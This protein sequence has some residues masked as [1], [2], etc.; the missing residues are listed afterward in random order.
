MSHSSSAE[1][2]TAADASPG[3]A[4]GPTGMASPIRLAERLDFSA[5]RDLHDQL[6][7]FQGRPVHLDGTGVRLCSALAAQVLLASARAWSAGGDDWSLSASPAL[8]DDLRLLGLQSAFP[9]P[10]EV[11]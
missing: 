5:A 2:A 10:V 1:A 4:S 11:V 9:N 8:R 6:A 7:E 3:L